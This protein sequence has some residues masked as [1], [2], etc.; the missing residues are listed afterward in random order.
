MLVTAADDLPDDPAGVERWP[1]PAHAEPSASWPTSTSPGGSCRG[2]MS[3]RDRAGPGRDAGR[4]RLRPDEPRRRRPP[5]RREG[6]GLPGGARR[7]GRRRRA[8]RTRSS[9]SPTRPRCCL[10]AGVTAFVQPGGSIRDAE[11]LGARREGR[12]DDAH[13]GKA[14][15]PA[16]TPRPGCA[17]PEGSAA[18]HHGVR[19][20]LDECGPGRKLPVGVRPTL[21]ATRI[22]PSLS[23]RASGARA[24]GVPKQARR[25]YTRPLSD[26]RRRPPGARRSRAL[27]PS[28]DHVRTPPLLPH[29]RDRVR[30]QPARP[31]HRCTR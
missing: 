27:L 3:Q 31:P 24:S 7:R 8:P 23:A 16:L 6:A 28:P 15:L 4:P 17:A 26:R 2:V 22:D 20:G 9:R 1:R 14:P 11:V 21:A 10:E 5:G 18:T 30:Q 13:H 12:R 19:P 29:D 25:R